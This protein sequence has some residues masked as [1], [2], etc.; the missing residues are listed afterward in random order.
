MLLLH[1]VARAHDLR[2]GA[3]VGM[4]TSRLVRWLRSPCPVV[5]GVC[6]RLSAVTK[7]VD[8]M[9]NSTS[10]VG[11]LRPRADRWRSGPAGA[12]R[13]PYPPLRLWTLARNETGANPHRAERT[14]PVER[15]RHGDVAGRV[16]STSESFQERAHRGDHREPGAARQILPWCRPDPG[17]RARRMGTP[18]V[19]R[20]HG[21]RPTARRGECPCRRD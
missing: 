14:P 6:T 11:R 3:P 9:R 18:A 17:R 20:R 10:R 1:S 5:R 8:N 19:P 21:A 13:R 16:P 15:R 12:L 2:R 7:S 4:P